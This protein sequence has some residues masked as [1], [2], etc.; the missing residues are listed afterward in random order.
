MT[1]KITIFDLVIH[2]PFNYII[3]KKKIEL[4]ALVILDDR[5][6]ASEQTDHASL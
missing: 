1:V 6:I 3:Y 5:S 4:Q 2:S